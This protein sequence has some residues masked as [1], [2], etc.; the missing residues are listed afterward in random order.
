MTCRAL[1]RLNVP[2]YDPPACCRC[3]QTPLEGLRYVARVKGIEPSL[4]AWDADRSAEL[5]FWQ[6]SQAIHGGRSVEQLAA[7]RLAVIFLNSFY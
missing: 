4:S 6:Q 5:I 3:V 2:Q 1:V 7:I